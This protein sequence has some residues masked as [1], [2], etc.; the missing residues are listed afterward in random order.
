MAA[1]NVWEVRHIDLKTAFL[2][3]E[4]YD[5]L[6]DVICQLPPE[7][8]HPPHIGARLKKPAYG[9]ND[10]PRRWWNVIDTALRK[11]GMMPT[12]ADRCCYVLCSNAKPA[13]AVK[14]TTKGK[15]DDSPLQLIEQAIGYLTDP[16]SG[17]NANGRTVQGIICLHVDDLFITG[18]PELESRVLVPL[19]KKFQV[20]SEDKGDIVHGTARWMGR[21]R[22]CGRSEQGY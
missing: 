19:R 9:L 15:K 2:Q 13:P 1:T 4:H 20:R 5:Q 7:A 14:E 3:G 8:G 11:Y 17:C 21:R 18:G 22:S 12:R 16:A 6:R 10:A